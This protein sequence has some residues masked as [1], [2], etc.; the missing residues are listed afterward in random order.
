[1]KLQTARLRNDYRMAYSLQA[2]LL[3][4]VSPGGNDTQSTPVPPVVIDKILARQT[5]DEV[6]TTI[7]GILDLYRPPAENAAY[8]SLASLADVL[9]RQAGRC[10]MRVSAHEDPLPMLSY[11]FD[12]E[13]ERALCARD[14]DCGGD[15]Y[16]IWVPASDTADDASEPDYIFHFDWG[17]GTVVPPTPAEVSFG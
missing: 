15:H 9:S 10:K 4:L 17:H 14:A 1:M 6:D 8:A 2:Q 11:V 5:A 3:V 7:A 16:W 12:P 13:L